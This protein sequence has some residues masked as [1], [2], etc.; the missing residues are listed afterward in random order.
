MTRDEV[1]E[2]I[3]PAVREAWSAHLRIPFLKSIILTVFAQL[4]P[5]DEVREGLV[6]VEKAD[7]DEARKLSKRLVRGLS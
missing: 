4:Q 2:R 3:T 6:V 1:I 5:G 7:L